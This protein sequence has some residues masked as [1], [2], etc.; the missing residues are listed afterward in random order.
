MTEERTHTYGG[1]ALW[2]RR[3]WWEEE[4]WVVRKV[5]RGLLLFQKTKILNGSEKNLYI[6]KKKE[7]NLVVFASIHSI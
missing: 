5:E 3:R 1:L 6:L 4:E 2:M 7:E